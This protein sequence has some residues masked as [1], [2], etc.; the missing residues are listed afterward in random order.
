[1]ARRPA[2]VTQAEIERAF[3]G[4]LAA[5][6][7]REAIRMEIDYRRGTIRIE[8][9]PPADIST[10]LAGAPEEREREDAPNYFDQFLR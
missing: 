5:G 6:I 7:P 1:M 4:V 2:T 9:G 10:G 3:K 8:A